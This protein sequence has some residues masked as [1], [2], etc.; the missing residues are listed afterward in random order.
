MNFIMKVFTIQLDQEM[1]SSL[2]LKLHVKV[3][4]LHEN[5]NVLF[6]NTF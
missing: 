3:K 1:R 5:E 2:D 4:R 6:G